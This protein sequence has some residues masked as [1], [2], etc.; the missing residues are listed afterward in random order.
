[1][2]PESGLNDAGF[3]IR[4]PQAGCNTYQLIER[5]NAIGELI[6]SAKGKAYVLL[7]GWIELTGKVAVLRPVGH[8]HPSH[9]SSLFSGQR[10]YH[11]PDIDSN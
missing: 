3:L 6:T 2:Q 10:A 7:T 8:E 1:L 5:M 4:H 9:E 11:S